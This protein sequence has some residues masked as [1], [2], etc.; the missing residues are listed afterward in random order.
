MSS[1]ITLGEGQTRR[2]MAVRQQKTVK[3]KVST[4]WQSLDSSNRTEVTHVTSH[5]LRTSL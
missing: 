5:F 3:N 1:K 2:D 4:E